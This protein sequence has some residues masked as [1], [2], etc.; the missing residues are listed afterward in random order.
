MH[1]FRPVHVIAAVALLLLPTWAAADGHETYRVRKDGGSRIT[2]VSNAML[3]TITG[4]SSQV[5]GS[6]RIRPDDLSQV[7]GRV[8]APVA[9]FRTG[10]DLRDEHLR[11]DKWLNADKNP[12]VVFEIERVTGARKLERGKTVAF[13]MHGKATLN[14]VTRPVVADA[15]ARYFPYEEVKGTMGIDGDVIRGRARF[16]LEL[17]EHGVSIP[18]S[19]RLKVANEITVNIDLRAVVDGKA[20]DA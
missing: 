14:G 11:S 3:E 2:F 4:V 16:N 15:K 8:Q 7:S 18:A 17:S 20:E 12:N 6:L 10:I 9:S 5:H 19:V 1:R 13:K